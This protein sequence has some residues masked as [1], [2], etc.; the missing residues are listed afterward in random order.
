MISG[1]FNLRIL[2]FASFC[3]TK[4]KQKVKAKRSLPALL[5]FKI[6][7]QKRA[8]ALLGSSEKL[9]FTPH[10]RRVLPAHAHLLMIVP[11]KSGDLNSKGRLKER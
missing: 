4:K 3:L 6:R 10:R 8:K 2:F 5:I 7:N 1:I 9:K 11:L